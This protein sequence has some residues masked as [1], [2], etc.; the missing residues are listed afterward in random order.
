MKE[1]KPLSAVVALDF[2]RFMKLGEHWSSWE[3]PTCRRDRR[4]WARFQVAALA[5]CALAGGCAHGISQRAEI[6]NVKHGQ[7]NSGPD[8]DVTEHYQV[9][10]PDVLAIRVAGRPALD[11]RQTV[12]VDGRIDLGQN[13]KVRA[14]GNTPDE[15]R[16]LVAAQLGVEPRAAQVRVAEYHSQQLFLF[17]QAVG[18]QRSAPYVGQETVLDLLQRVGVLTPG[19]K[20]HDVYVVRAHIADAGRPEVY[21]VDLENVVV[22]HEQKTNL[23]LLPNDQVYIAETR[24]DIIERLL[25]PWLQPLFQAFAPLA[26]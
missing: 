8:R 17:G 12:G 16:A 1:D 7:V 19:A 14:A 5:C 25:P 11:I 6:E 24:Q 3:K 13:G 26:K 20:P 21:H 10:C 18:W 23:R 15:I 4:G 9:G 22:R 2:R